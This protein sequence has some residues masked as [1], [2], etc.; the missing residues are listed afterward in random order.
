MYDT[1][2]VGIGGM[3]SAALA[4]LA[5]RGQRVLGIE[6]FGVPHDRGSSH[7]I[8]RI[9]RLAY[10][11]HPAYVPLLRRAYALWRELSEES[12]RRLLTITGSLDIDVP[13]GALYEGSLAACALHRLAHEDLSAEEIGRRFPGY[14]LPDPI[15]GVLQPDGGYVM[16]EEA[17][18]AHAEVARRYG[19]S[20]HLWES[21]QAWEPKGSGVRVTTDRGT[22]DARR[23]V[24][25][26]GSW[27]GTLVPE[28]R[29]VAVPERQ[30]IAWFDP[31]EPALY[32]P[33]RFPVFNMRVPEGTFYGIPIEGIPGLKIGRWHHLGEVVDPDA[34]DRSTGA[35]DESVLRECV[36]RYFP[37]ANGP[38]LS[39]A[40]CMFTNTPDE[41]FIID[42]HPTVPRVIVAAGFSGHGYKFCSVVGEIIAD[43]AERGETGQDISMFRLDRFAGDGGEVTRGRLH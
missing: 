29:E 2:V 1:I 11:E 40:A 8:T 10:F 33:A 7:G 14:C 32:A 13:G 4:H 36:A 28:L 18:V 31:I 27:S 5:K 25:T 21:V 12:G 26:A 43:L 39:M 20:L 38:V 19:A 9:I 15:R 34:L 17:I 35:R 6:R 16:S 37:Q 30:V 41:H 42:R 22:Y 3:G 24:L 23:L